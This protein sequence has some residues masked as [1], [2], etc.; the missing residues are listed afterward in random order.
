MR[1]HPGQLAE[2]HAHV[3]LGAGFVDILGTFVPLAHFSR[4]DGA[5][6]TLH[7]AVLPVMRRER[8]AVNELAAA[9]KAKQSK[10]V[11]A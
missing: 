8:Q 3:V 5:T 4:L 9:L 10:T 1:E 6:D 7:T 2:S 11:A